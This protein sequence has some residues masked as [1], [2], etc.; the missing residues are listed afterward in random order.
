MENDFF[1]LAEQQFTHNI[2]ILCFIYS[3]SV[4]NNVAKYVETIL[5]SGQIIWTAQLLFKKF[6]WDFQ[7]LSDY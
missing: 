3:I 1:S 7:I 5:I 2:A 6:N 4:K